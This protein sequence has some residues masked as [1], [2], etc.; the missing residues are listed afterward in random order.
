MSAMAQV[1]N[2]PS[3]YKANALVAFVD[4]PKKVVGFVAKVT[5]SDKGGV[6]IW[7]HV[8]L[9]YFPFNEHTIFSNFKVC[10][11]IRNENEIKNDN[12]HEGRDVVQNYEEWVRNIKT[13]D[14]IELYY[15][16]LLPEDRFDTLKEVYGYDWKVYMPLSTTP[17][18][19]N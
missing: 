1:Y 7:R 11:N 19:S 10:D 6:W 13:G 2:L 17:L 14:F 18:C 9:E 3:P 15:Q 5:P 8:R 16:K 4:G 12:P